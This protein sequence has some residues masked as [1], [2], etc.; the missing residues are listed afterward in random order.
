ML[1]KRLSCLVWLH[2]FQ[3]LMCILNTAKLD[4]HFGGCLLTYS[5]NSRNIIRTVAHQCFQL[6]NLRR[7]YL[8]FLKN[9]RCVVVFNGC[10]TP[11]C[12]RQTDQ[13]LICSKLE[14]ISVSGKNGNIHPLR[15]TP[16]GNRTKKIICLISFQGHDIDSHRGKHFPDQGNLFPEFFRHRLTSPLVSFISLVAECRCA[17]IKS[18]CQIF[19]IFLLHNPEHNVQ[20]SIYGSCMT[21]LGIGKIRQSVERTVQNAVSVDQ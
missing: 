8:I 11:D 7:C 17:Q 3:M 16:S 10:L 1:P 4:D 2:F 5:W 21:A 9:F 12:L 19:R 14:K 13:D 15:F 18:N 20:K 6:D